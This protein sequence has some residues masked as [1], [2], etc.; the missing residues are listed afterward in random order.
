LVSLVLSGTVVDADTLAGLSDVVVAARSLTG[1]DETDATR[2]AQ[3][4]GPF[5]AEDGSFELMFSRLQGSFFG[6]PG[7]LLGQSM[8]PF[9]GFPPPDQVEVIVLRGACEERFLIDINEDTVVD[10][11]FP[12]DVIELQNPILVPPCGSAQEGG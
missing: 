3:G 1:G 10:L 12:G 5:P 9:S 8:P 4:I 11:E 2:F 7:L 6:L